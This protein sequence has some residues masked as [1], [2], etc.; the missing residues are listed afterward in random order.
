MS[1]AA[2]IGKGNQITIPRVIMELHGFTE[3]DII[4]VVVTRI[5]GGA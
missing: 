4:D 1:F 5:K 2:K 3:G